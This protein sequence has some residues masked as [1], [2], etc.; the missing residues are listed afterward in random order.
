[1]PLRDLLVCNNMKPYS[2]QIC[3]MRALGIEIAG[4]NTRAVVLDGP[5][6]VCKI[7]I[8]VPYNLPLPPDS[9][10]INRLIAL[11]K[12]VFDLLKSGLVE[13]AGIIRADPG[14]SPLRAKIECVI[15]MAAS[16]AAITCVLVPAQTVWAAEKRK[17]REVA[18]LSV[19]EALEQVSPA[20]LRK[21]AFCGWCV[22]ND[23]QR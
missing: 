18:G 16:D 7:E 9:K 21:A 5:P 17:V 20:Y 15:Q 19:Q 22:L 4:S 14:S 3:G 10:E 1:M 13:R 6:E 23:K 8:V 2:F 12:Q 11:K